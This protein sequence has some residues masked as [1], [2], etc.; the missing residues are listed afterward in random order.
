M[1][2]VTIW[3]PS[4]LRTWQT[5][6]PVFFQLRHF[7]ETIPTQVKRLDSLFV[8]VVA[9]R[10]MEEERLFSSRSDADVF[11]PF[12]LFPSIPPRTL[13]V[14]R[15]VSRIGGKNNQRNLPT[16]PRRLSSVS[17]SEGASLALPLQEGKLLSQK[18][19]FED[20]GLNFKYKML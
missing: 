2:V 13:Q 20:L 10:W 9:S 6:T 1:I 18:L 3:R 16:K 5:V 7:G 17:P 15:R 11:C 4:R 19:P 8:A 12:W 14:P